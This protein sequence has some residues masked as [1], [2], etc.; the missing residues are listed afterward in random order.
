[1][2]K[3]IPKTNITEKVD[4]YYTPGIT[5]KKIKEENKSVLNKK[6]VEV[7]T[8]RPVSKYQNNR[9]T[10]SSGA[11][12]SVSVGK[13]QF[14]NKLPSFTPMVTSKKVLN[15]SPRQ[16]PSKRYGKPA[17]VQKS[18]YSQL[19]KKKATKTELASVKVDESHLDGNP[20]D[21]HDEQADELA[22][23]VVSP[24]IIKAKTL[25]KATPMVMPSPKAATLK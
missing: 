16:T 15:L 6:L 13:S 22:P 11:N 20:M 24:P 21:A 18:P 5:Q 14:K 4:H 19:Q 10:R 8:S 12:R 2:K 7:K 3:L 1:M 25:K 9:V 17:A 23:K